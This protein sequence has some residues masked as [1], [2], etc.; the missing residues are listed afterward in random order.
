MFRLSLPANIIAVCLLAGAGGLPAAAQAKTGQRDPLPAFEQSIEQGRLAETERPLLDFAL[1]QPQNARALELVGRLRF[2]QGRLQEAKALY[3]RALSLDASSVTAKI[4]YAVV[5]FQVGQ[6]EE[7]KQFL[8]EIDESRIKDA[9]VLLGLTQALMLTGDYRRS[10][11][12]AEKLPEATRNGD[13]LPTLLISYLGLGEK[14]KAE[15]LVPLAKKNGALKPAAALK[16]AEVLLSGGMSAPA[17]ELLRSIVA[18]APKNTRALLLLAK[19]EIGA[20][21]FAGA[22]A[23]LKEAETLQPQSAEVLYVKGLLENT[24]GNTAA[25]LDWLEKAAA[26]SPNSTAI[27]KDLAV[28]AIRASQPRKAVG[29]AEKLVAGNPNDPDF[30]YLYGASLLQ[31]GNLDAAQKSLERLMQL[32]P[33]DSR[34][35]LALGLTLAAQRDR[36]EPARRQLERCLE[37]S[38]ANY[39]AKYQLGLSYKA[40]GD[41]ASAIKYLEETVALSPGYSLA[42]R[43]LGAVYLQAGEES[44]A[45]AALE[46]ALLINQGDAETHFQLSRLYNLTGDPALAKKHL[47][48]FQKLRT[49]GGNTMQ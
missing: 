34:G 10:L 45:R 6:V 12:A 28:T 29:A 30:L 27:L 5:L 17:L 14:Q 37:I 32:R 26:L 48:L 9:G 38:P 11:A 43:D 16:F 46:K 25:A 2:R 20:N 19:A 22:L 47:E 42:L 23:H 7:A 41:T 24:R 39:E 18:A 49:P 13:A 4:D 31:S 3:M 35:C 33:A 15:A 36:I 21:D 40:Q 44:K 8:A 1:S